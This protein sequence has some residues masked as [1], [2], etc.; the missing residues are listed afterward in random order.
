MGNK[1]FENISYDYFSNTSSYVKMVLDMLPDNEV[2]IEKKQIIKELYNYFLN[3][4]DEN[5]IKEISL[6]SSMF[7]EKMESS[8]LEDAKRYAKVIYTYF[9]DKI[10]FDSINRKQIF[11]IMNDSMKVY[12]GYFSHE[13]VIENNNSARVN[14]SR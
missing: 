12:V 2:S 9:L 14:Y 5:K 11:N 10:I 4:F 8:S 13:N 3:Q 1:E 7:R 6:V